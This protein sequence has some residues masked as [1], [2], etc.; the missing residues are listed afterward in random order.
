MLL[1]SMVRLSKSLSWRNQW[2]EK[3]T[4]ST[5]ITE[6]EEEEGFLGR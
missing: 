2:M 1:S 4:M 6:E 5:F 3:T